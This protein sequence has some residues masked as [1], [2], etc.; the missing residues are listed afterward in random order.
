MTSSFEVKQPMF[1]NRCRL[2]HKFEGKL[3]F[4]SRTM[5]AKAIKLK[6]VGLFRNT[7][8]HVTSSINEHLLW[9]E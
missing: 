8:C 5:I 6:G 1:S 3:A 7:H 9:C 4:S 2:L